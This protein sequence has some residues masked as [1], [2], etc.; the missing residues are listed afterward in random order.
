MPK[1]TKYAQHQTKIELMKTRLEVFECTSGREG[2]DFIIKT[3][4]K[5]TTSFIYNPL[6]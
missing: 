2:V 3:S 4:Q 6:I 5:T 1:R